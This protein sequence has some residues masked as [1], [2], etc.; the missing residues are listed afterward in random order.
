MHIQESGEMYLETIY[1]LS[2][3]TGAVR[4]IDVGEYMGYSKPSV[5]RAV[6]ILKKGGYLLMD[7]DGYLTLTESGLAV[8]KKIYERHT[9]LTDF[10]IRLGVNEKTAVEDACK[11]EHDISDE[12]FDALK[13]HAK[14]HSPSA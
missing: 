7:K 4:S 11:I 1:I 13:K 12:T 6:G 10:L 2:E 5:S 3:K 14:M 9:L 8:A